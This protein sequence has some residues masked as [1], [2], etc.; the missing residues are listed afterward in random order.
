ML[1][2]ENVLNQRDP[3]GALKVASKQYEQTKFNAVVNNPEHDDRPI[4]NIV[5]AGMGGSAL[6]ALVVKTWLK[7]EF[8]EPFEVVRTYDLPN[9]VDKDTLVIISSYSGNTEESI[10][11]LN[12]AK[13]KGAQIA[14][15]ASGGQL[16]NTSNN[17][18]IAYV[19]LPAGIQPRYGVIYNLCALVSLLANFGIVADDKI[20]E[21]SGM[22]DWLKSESEKWDFGVTTNDNYAKKLALSAVGKTAIFY[23]G[24]L[25]APVAYK[26]KI[27]WN[28]N[29]KNLA[30]WNEIPEFSHNEFIGWTSHP[31]EKPF[32]VF[33]IVSSFEHPQILKRFEITD[34]LL[35][36]M[37]PKSTVVNL[38]GDT[39]I[40]QML[41]GS[42]LA[43]YVSI[44]IAI[45]NGVDPTPVVL[46]EKLKAELK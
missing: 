12:Q 34:R 35:S 11:C 22:Y 27:S 2:D 14:V 9:Y 43:D 30:F 24:A 18:N 17:D 1:D 38:A 28:E 4:Y 26:W 29:A 32:A 40:K 37:R 33:D 46:I 13:T 6:A 15:I 16:I 45:L 19:K 20:S 21:V 5:V 31:V 10:S 23:G 39:L 8:P 36:G 7:S 44:Y 41:W 25:S 42:I 3:A